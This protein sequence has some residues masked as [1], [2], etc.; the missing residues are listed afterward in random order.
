MDKDTAPILIPEAEDLEEEED[1]FVETIER[2][3]QNQS[4]AVR[5]TIDR[6]DCFGRGW[7]IDQAEATD[8]D[9]DEG[10]IC[11]EVECE[12]RY[13]CELVHKRVSENE[14]IGTIESSVIQPFYKKQVI[15]KKRGRPFKV[16][17]EFLSRRSK[18]GNEKTPYVDLGRTIDVIADKIWKAVGSPPSLPENWY[19]QTT[20]NTEIMKL[21]RS[22]IDKVSQ[23]T[24][25]DKYGEGLIITRRFNWHQYFF[26]GIHLM[27]LW[28]WAASGGW[29]D[30]NKH[31][32][33]IM[34]KQGKA[35]LEMPPEKARK[36]K[37]RHFPYRMYVSKQQHLHRLFEG[38]TKY[39]GLSVSY[40][41][42]KRLCYGDNK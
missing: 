25:M 22:E 4:P 8:F 26:N 18:R 9:E 29:L 30:L 31:L 21:P 12:L 35:E 10:G 37:Y 7:F 1:N 19:Y 27:R 16:D 36:K 38:L 11:T 5:D 39:E 3:K 34:V 14:R 33:K 42:E 13:L 24:F 15:K 23:R 2:V 17:K 28:V 20:F 32:S 41:E 6:A 40:I